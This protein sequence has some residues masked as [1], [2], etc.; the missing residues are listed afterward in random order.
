MI[1]SGSSDPDGKIARENAKKKAEEN[2]AAK[3]KVEKKRAEKK[4][5]Q[6]RIEK[7]RIEKAEVEGKTDEFTISAVGTDVRSVTA[8]LAEGLSSGGISGTV[9]F[10]VKA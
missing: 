3:E 7:R 8:K 2:K 9:G 4:A 10:D 5:E 1:I 6:E